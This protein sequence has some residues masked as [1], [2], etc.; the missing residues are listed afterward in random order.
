[1]HIYHEK[2]YNIYR[3]T[4]IQDDF[5]SMLILFLRLNYE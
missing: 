1:M 5:I 3:R 4:Y 2:L